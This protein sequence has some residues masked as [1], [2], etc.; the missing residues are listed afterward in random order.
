MQLFAFPVHTSAYSSDSN[1]FHLYHNHFRKLFDSHSNSFDILSVQRI[2]EMSFNNSTFLSY[3]LASKTS[4]RLQ[5]LHQQAISVNSNLGV[6]ADIGTTKG[7][8][9]F[10]A[11]S[12]KFF[13]PSFEKN[14]FKGKYLVMLNYKSL[15]WK[16]QENGGLKDADGF[17][18]NKT[19]DSRTIPV[20]MNDAFSEFNSKSFFIEQQFRIPKSLSDSGITTDKFSLRNVTFRNRCKKEFSAD[21]IYSELFMNTYLDTNS[22]KDSVMVSELLNQTKAEYNLSSFFNFDSDKREVHLTIDANFHLLESESNGNSLPVFRVFQFE[23]GLSFRTDRL[24]A[25]IFF[26][27]KFYNSLNTG[28]GGGTDVV[29]NLPSSVFSL[30]ILSQDSCPPLFYFH[31]YSN[32]FI[33]ERSYQSIRDYAVQLNYKKIWNKWMISSGIKMQHWKNHHYLNSDSAPEVFQESISL[34]RAAVH[35]EYNLKHWKLNSEIKMQNSDQNNLLRQPGIVQIFQVFFGDSIFKS[36]AMLQTGPGVRYVSGFI[37]PS[38]NPALQ[39]N[40]NGRE[41][42]SKGFYQLNYST[43]L[44]LDKAE[45]YFSAEHLNAG[46]GSRNY[47][48]AVDYPLPGL[49]LKFGVKW[50]LEK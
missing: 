18:A 45:I 19:N 14:F 17:T 2:P 50:L 35:V 32:H 40:F 48:Y 28:Y 4:Q 44:T 25:H 49:V 34:I 20:K 31:T 23:P 21:G 9:P 37:L 26:T 16:K 41:V 22:T 33:W 46:W 27:S 10:Q 6:L 38:F 13:N 15:S 7:Y 24:N 39:Q 30:S 5:L 36:K 43:Y 11:E 42:K 8:Y 29:F 1:S 47:F 12:F 3:Q